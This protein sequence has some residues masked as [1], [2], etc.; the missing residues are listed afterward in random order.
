MVD[1]ASPNSPRERWS[2]IFRRQQPRQRTRFLDVVQHVGIDLGAL[3][4]APAMIP[5]EVFR[6][7]HFVQLVVDASHALNDF[8]PLD[9]VGMG[10]VHEPV[11]VQLTASLRVDHQVVQQGPVVVQLRRT[12]LEISVFGPQAILQGRRRFGGS[13]DLAKALPVWEPLF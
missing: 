1:S 4:V 12:R 6:D 7:R 13:R 2:S 3:D 9:C 10:R 11:L 5:V 8:V